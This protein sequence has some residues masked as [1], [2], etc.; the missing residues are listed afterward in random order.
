MGA[1][2]ADCRPVHFTQ[3]DGDQPG[4]AGQPRPS[5]VRQPAVACARAARAN[6]RDRSTPPRSRHVLRSPFRLPP[7]A[8]RQNS[9]D[10]GGPLW[11]SDG[12]RRTSKTV[13][14]R[15]W[16]V[17]RTRTSAPNP[18]A[19]KIG[20]RH[21]PPPS[22]DLRLV[23]RRERPLCMTQRPCAAT[24]T[25][26]LVGAVAGPAR[27]ADRRRIRRPARL[28][29]VFG[30][31][32]PETGRPLSWMVLQLLA[33]ATVVALVGMLVPPRDARA[34]AD[35]WTGLTALVADAGQGI[36]CRCP[37]APRDPF[38]WRPVRFDRALPAAGLGEESCR[39]RPRAARPTWHFG[40]MEINF[41][42][43]SDALLICE[44][45]SAVLP[46]GIR[47]AGYRPILR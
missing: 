9:P 43:K 31:E 20:T 26:H 22:R 42:A 2:P 13:R 23:A 1:D 35:Y 6:I 44:F 14:V 21:S 45:V 19:Q 11:T 33:V 40:P 36:C 30:N 10:L 37:S 4:R 17:R 39:R 41:V 12:R 34:V 16:S 38:R 47:S 24:R 29:G 3:P 25:D 8:T 7:A 27:H 5:V 15:T 18:F 28:G 46:A 32:E